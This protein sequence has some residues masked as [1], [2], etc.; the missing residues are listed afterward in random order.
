MSRFLL[1]VLV[2]T[3]FSGVA[4]AEICYTPQEAEAEQGIKIHSELMVIALNCA[5]M[6]D[7]NGHNLYSEYRKYTAAH[8][9][10]FA[11]Y[12]KILMAH[13]KKNGTN[14]TES[15]MNALRTDMATKVSNDS[16]KMRP[17]IFCDTYASRIEKVV[18]MDEETFRKWAATPFKGHPLTY[19][20]CQN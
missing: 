20:M 18:K 6:A 11:T 9:K 13:M 3:L 19:P 10:L 1:L 7:A 4:H 14:D 2:A 5:H 17:D 16:A 12:E 8:G 15:K